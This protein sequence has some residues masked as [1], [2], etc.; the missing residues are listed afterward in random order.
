MLARGGRIIY[1]EIAFE[2]LFLMLL[3]FEVADT[4]SSL[5]SCLFCCCQVS[6]IATT[7][8]LCLGEHIYFKILFYFCLYAATFIKLGKITFKH[9]STAMV[10]R[11][12]NC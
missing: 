7:L 11:W 8:A 3:L 1:R 5:T 6:V 12:Y 4:V 2:V 9:F 10:V